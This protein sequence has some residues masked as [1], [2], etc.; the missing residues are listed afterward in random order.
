MIQPALV[1]R[2]IVYRRP[3]EV[4]DTAIP[5]SLRS[6]SASIAVAVL[7]MFL[8]GSQ[9]LLDWANNLPVATT[10]GDTLSSLAQSWNDAMTRLHLTNFA[11]FLRQT[12]Q[13]FQN[14]R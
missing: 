12:W 8:L 5:S 2:E 14:F 6:V 4:V 1:K 10:I 9:G 13:A 11:D 7:V 3:I